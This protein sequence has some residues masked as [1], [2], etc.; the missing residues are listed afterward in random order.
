MSVGLSG[1]ENELTSRRDGGLI[2]HVAAFAARR[3]DHLD[4]AH[5]ARLVDVEGENHLSFAARRRRGG[6]NRLHEVNET[7]WLEDG[8]SFRGVCTGDLRHR[9]HHRDARCEGA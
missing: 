6:Q 5:L 1:L 4:G 8:R 3:R 9:N 2:E 7:R